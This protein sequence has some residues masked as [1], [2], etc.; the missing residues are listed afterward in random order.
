[1]VLRGLPST[2][3]VLREVEITGSPI[4]LAV[5]DEGTMLAVTYDTSI[6]LVGRNGESRWL[7]TL[8]PPSALAFSNS[9]GDLLMA[10]AANHAVYWV[11]DVGGASAV[12]RL[13]GERDGITEPVGV[14]FS[15]D[16][17]RAIV[18]DAGSQAIAAIDLAG[19]VINR[20]ACRV[21][22]T[23]LYP[24]GSGVYRFTAPPRDEPLWLYE[25]RAGRARVFFVPPELK[26]DG[27]AALQLVNNGERSGQ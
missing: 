8:G 15:S 14:A 4:G 6:L 22:P 21:K 9:G 13:A 5:N 25:A 10:D 23:G 17:R 16:D 24:L 7:L 26:A 20:A 27:A 12:V 18:A 2:P 1:V 3:Q 19:G 11:R